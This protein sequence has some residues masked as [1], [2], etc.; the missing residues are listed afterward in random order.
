[1]G[2]GR[3]SLPPDEMILREAAEDCLRPNMRLKVTALF[4]KEAICCLAFEMS[5]AA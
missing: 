5:A 1:M 4:S 3:Y 2:S